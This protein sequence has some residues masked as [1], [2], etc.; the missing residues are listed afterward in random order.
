[1]LLGLMNK[2]RPAHR[3]ITEGYWLREEH[4]GLELEGK[5]I[6]LIG[7]GNTGK[8]FAKKL[9]GFN[10]VKVLCYDILEGVGDLAAEQV[11]LKEL[12]KKAHVVSLHIPETSKTLGFI[13][14][15]FINNMHHPFWL[16]NTAR[17]KVI[18]T[19]ELVEGLKTRKILGAGLDV[20]EYESSSFYSIFKSNKQNSALSYL[21]KSDQVL[22]SPHVG[23]WTVES[24]HKLAQTILD[25]IKALSLIV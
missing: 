16:I 7:Y 20:L 4:R 21:L 10:D 23:G 14:K 9:Q 11:S 17:G 12:L 5:T 13:N 8:S 19:E 25:K 24:H 2:L 1:M 15:K 18:I 22:L 6:G 3:S